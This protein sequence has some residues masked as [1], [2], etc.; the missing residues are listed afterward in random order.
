[1]LNL[2]RLSVRLTRLLTSAAFVFALGL[3]LTPAAQA[4][5]TG[6]CS[7]S[8]AAKIGDPPGQIFTGTPLN[9]QFFADNRSQQ[10]PID[11]LGFVASQLNCSPVANSA[12]VGA[13]GTCCVR[14]A[15]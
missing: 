12:G 2:D 3:G 1:M 5:Q 8:C 4:Q 9:F 10:L 7:A 6:N 13:S 14:P 11:G 15:W